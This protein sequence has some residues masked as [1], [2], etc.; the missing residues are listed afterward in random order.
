MLRNTVWGPNERKDGQGWIFLRALRS[1]LIRPLSVV[2]R[3]GLH[4]DLVGS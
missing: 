1:D 4:S 3:G 2:V